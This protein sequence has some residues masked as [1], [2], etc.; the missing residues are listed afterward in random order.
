MLHTL[1]KQKNK[2]KSHYRLRGSATADYLQ[3]LNTIACG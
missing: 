1:H 2:K 3:I